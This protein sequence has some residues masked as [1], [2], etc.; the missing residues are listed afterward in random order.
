MSWFTISKLEIA[1]LMCVTL[2]CIGRLSLGFVVCVP[3]GTAKALKLGL[4]ALVVISAFLV[5]LG[6][7]CVVYVYLKRLNAE[8]EAER[9]KPCRSVYVIG[10][11]FTILALVLN[12]II[13]FTI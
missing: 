2:Y 4:L 11:S 8:L 12:L 3:G 13:D 6:L 5:W 10:Y 9:I 1:L 7:L